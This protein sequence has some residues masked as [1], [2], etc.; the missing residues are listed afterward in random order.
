MSANIEDLIEE[1]IVSLVENVDIDK[2]IAKHLDKVH[3]I[4]IRYRVL[5][6]FLQSLNIRFGDFI[7]TLLSKIIASS[8]NLE[9]L[10]SKRKDIKLE[11]NPTCEEEINKYIDYPLRTKEISKK[12]PTKLEKL[13]D[14][15]FRYQLH[16]ESFVSKPLD[17]DNLFKYKS[18]ERYYYVEIKYNDDHDTGKFQDINR[19]MLKTYAGLVRYLNVKSK[20]EF[21]PIL[22]YFN[23][24]RRHPSPYLR[25]GIEILRAEELFQKFNL[26]ISYEDVETKLNEM[27]DR[28]EKRFDEFEEQIFK[29]VKE[30]TKGKQTTLL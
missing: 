4:P 11:L 26:L 6:G 18:E 21:K 3:F 8:P 17:V 14:D 24:T 7:E 1:S 25:E 2:L 28:L 13:Y 30:R 12:L 15:V 19:K 29:R 5:N 9:V 10:L 22:Y 27:E 23:Y 16:G 20:E